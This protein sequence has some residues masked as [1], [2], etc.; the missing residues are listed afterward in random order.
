MHPQ[1]SYRQDTTVPSFADDKPIIV[2]DGHCVL[3]SGWANFVLK[4]D[5]CRVYRLLA[6]QSPLGQALYAH[7]GLGGADYQS[8]LLVQSGRVFIK[9]EGSI[10]MAEGLGRPW[11]M[12]A[13]LRLLPL[14][15]RDWLYDVVARNRFR[16]FGRREVCYLPDAKDADRF[17]VGERL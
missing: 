6:A 1:Y 7:Y 3:C 9:S 11:R 5:R 15:W 10:R 14:A 2:F 8:N 13:L 12:A 4:H 16:W 17:V